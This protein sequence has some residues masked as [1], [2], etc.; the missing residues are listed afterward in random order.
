MI[1][2]GCSRCGGDMFPEDDDHQPGLACL[3]CGH[4]VTQRVGSK[5]ASATS[6]LESRAERR[7]LAPVS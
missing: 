5:P 6:V 4:R 2:K 1:L 7:W 3:Q